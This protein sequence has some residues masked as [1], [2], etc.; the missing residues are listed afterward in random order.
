MNIRLDEDDIRFRISLEEAQRLN[1]DLRLSQTFAFPERELRLEVIRVSDAALTLKRSTDDGLELR[2]PGLELETLLGLVL[3]EGATT[4]DPVIRGSVQ[5]SQ[6]G[7]LL[8]FEIDRFTL[9][10][11]RQSSL[12]R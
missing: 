12:S 11:R 3:E 8:L 10:G 5:L 4:L 6:K 7:A 2:V 9:R 1:R